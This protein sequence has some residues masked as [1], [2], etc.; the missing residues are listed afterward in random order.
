M[1]QVDKQSPDPSGSL[2]LFGL[3][4]FR[5]GLRYLLKKRL[6]YMAM[7]GVALSVV[8]LIVVMSVMMGFDQQLRSVIR[9]YQS[10]IK[11]TPLTS[12][13]YGFK[14]EKWKEVREMALNIAHAEAAAPF[15]DGPGLLVFS[16]GK[17]AGEHMQH[18]FFR[19]IDPQLE[20]GVSGF[21]SDFMS[22]GSL[23]DLARTYVTDT[24][25]ELPH[26]LIGSALADGSPFEQVMRTFYVHAATTRAGE[27]VLG[28]RSPGASRS[29]TAEQEEA[30][31]GIEGWVRAVGQE[32]P[33]ARR[34][35]IKALRGVSKDGLS[36]EARARL[37]EAVSLVESGLPEEERE[38]IARQFRSV[39]EAPDYEAAGRRLDEIIAGERARYPLAIDIFNL[40]PALRGGVVHGLR[41]L[42][43]ANA[44]KKTEKVPRRRH[45]PDRPL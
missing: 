9:G 29:I 16:E 32:K 6:S 26:C 19:G 22:E 3:T 43:V 18:V 33:K 11:V 34:A 31:S 45:V 21:D 41:G 14:E 39:R 20:P 27:L 17:K 24:G 30:V 10:D 5:V 13:L 28:L 4:P 15:I 42:L 37:Q 38:R 8:V 2:P 40:Y 12:R 35:A 23:A 7:L 1:P 25:S 36:P 44:R